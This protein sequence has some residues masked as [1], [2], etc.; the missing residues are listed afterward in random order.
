M[1]IKKDRGL[2][3]EIGFWG[4]SSNLVNIIVGAGI[5]VLPAIVAAGLGSA[6]I[7]AYLFCGFLILLIM[8]C[9]AEAGTRVTN[10]GG[11]Y[12]YLETA[13]GN[14]A[15]YL[16]A[17]FF[18]C[19]SITSDAAVANALAGVLS[20]VF[21]IFD[22]TW[23]RLVFFGVV[24]SGLAAINVLGVRQGIGLVKFTTVAKLVPLLLIVALGWTEVNVSN[25]QWEALPPLTDIGAISL[26][27][28]WAFQ[29]G[30]SGLA[31]SGEV[32]NP[33]K[34]IPKSIFV[35]IIGVLV[36]YGLIQVVSQGVL[37][38][39][40]ANS[41]DSPLAKVGERLLGPVGFTIVTLGAAFSMFGN[42]S[43]EIL[44]IP[45]VVYGAARDRAIPVKAL[46]KI[47]PRYGTPYVAI[48]FYT[49]TV[50]ILASVGGFKLLASLSGAFMLVI[51]I[52]VAFAVFRLRKTTPTTK[53]TYVIPGGKIIPVAAIA[54]GAWL[55]TG[56]DR[57]ALIGGGV[58]IA[59]LTVVFFLIRR[60][61]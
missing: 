27:L 23:V 5:F 53:E 24:F 46:A 13:F 1:K 60:R 33:R 48:I 49:T 20:S 35:S 37:G 59:A 15:G 10:T 29:G 14:Y 50:I 12:T 32:I 45:R 34:T 22:L 3:R 52:G 42:L 28:F 31:V 11:A 55:L 56:L 47:H 51:Y 40:L 58:F 57:I 36:L 54:A 8:F 4:L 9:F 41:Q 2:K 6:A 18:F 19:S 21:P 30:E 39:E 38:D 44:N 61:T 43:G 7:V 25:L 16:T 26:I 17:I